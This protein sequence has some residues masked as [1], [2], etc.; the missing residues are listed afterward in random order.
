M[1]SLNILVYGLIF[2]SGCGKDSESSTSP[3]I[4]NAACISNPPAEASEGQDVVYY[5]KEYE[6]VRSDDYKAQGQCRLTDVLRGYSAE[7]RP[8][9]SCPVQNLLGKCRLTDDGYPLTTFYYSFP[10]GLSSWP[11]TVST[12]EEHCI[13]EDEFSRKPAGNWITT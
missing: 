3:P 4:I 7:W 9:E 2:V 12:A 5:C 13:N 8:N 6:A 11:N 1:R 10:E